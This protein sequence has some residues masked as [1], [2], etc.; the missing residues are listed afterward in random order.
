MTG[1]K[2]TPKHIDDVS[3]L[4]RFFHYVRPYRAPLRTV[5]LL[6][7][8]NSFLNLL[9]AMSLRYYFD[10]VIDPKAVSVLGFSF[11]TRGVIVTWADK[12]SWSIGYFFAM[13]ALI[14]GANTIGVVMWR[15]GTRVSQRVLLDIKTHIMHHLHKLS[16][17]Y[18]SREQTG[19][20]MARAVG[21][22]M[23]MQQMIKQSF[24]VAYQ[25]LHLLVAPI[26][27]LI[28]S[29]QLFLVVL[30]PLPLIFWAIRRI[31]ILLRPLY[32]QQREKQAEVSA[33]V[34]EQISGI[35]EIKA[36][37]QEEEAQRDV[38][39]VNKAYMRSVNRAMRIFSVNH[40]VLYGT[41]DFAMVLLAAVGGAMIV[42]GV[43][44]VSIGMVMAFLPLMNHFF[45]PFTQLVGF[46]DILQRGMAST[47]RV[48]EFFDV[49]PDLK[50]EP[51]AK[52]A[53]LKEGRI[54]FDHVVF[55]YQP[56]QPVLKDI[57]L[58]IAPGQTIAIVGST[59]SGKSTLASL[60]PRFYDPQQGEIRIDDH[61]LKS[62]KMDA[63]RSA[64]GIVFQ[65]TFLFYGSIAQNIGFSKPGATP[66]EIVQAARLAN[67]HDFIM[68]LPHRY[69]SHI[70]ERGVTLSGGQRQRIAI[71]RMI[72]K[73]PAVII[74]DEATSALDTTTE[75][76]IKQSMDYLMKGRTSIVIAHRL[77][78]IRNADQIIVLEDGEIVETGT[79]DELVARNGRYCQLASAS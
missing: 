33:T 43:G 67:I 64:V 18:F 16:L 26:L 48:F 55:G 47:E 29:W 15:L 38:T 11:D 57:N 25:A 34:Q 9:P 45:A 40:Q 78:T 39:R 14:V 23:Q 63:I 41:R 73:D 79:H 37:G 69:E 52:W 44:D 72:L 3:L 60:I 2:P 36:F 49:Q 12:I 21:D 59:G 4:R 17:S 76:V 46:Y 8:L 65:E 27:M 66:D 54:T 28:M 71:A 31:R 22:V 53:D 24:A 32:R 61:P 42:T 58:D 68:T 13:L 20:V 77:S 75:A 51:G 30:V 6:Y 19:S 10:L 56:D 50:D 74:L 5:Y 1:E 7:F 70:G 35:R 62:V